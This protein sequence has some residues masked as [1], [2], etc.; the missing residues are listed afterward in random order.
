MAEI[1]ENNQVIV[2]REVPCTVRDGVKLYANIYR[3]NDGGIYPILL[4]RLPY[5]KNLPDF[6]HR[7]I[8]P[9]RTAMNGFIVV[10]QD[11]RG[12]FAS[13]GEFM[14]FE[15]EAED[16]Y[17]TVEW[18]ARLPYSDGN[19]GMFGLSYYGFTQLYAALEKPPSLKAVFP[20]MTGSISGEAF[21]RDGVFN[22]ASAETWILESVAPDYLKRKQ[23]SS[24]YAE[25]IKV[26]TNDLNKIEKWH[27]FKPINQWPPVTKHPELRELFRKYLNKVYLTD[28]LSKGT[29]TS[30]ELKLPAYHLAGWYDNFLGPTIKNYQ[31][32]KK[33]DH[34]QK[35]II[36]PWGHGAFNSE[37]GERSFGIT[38]SGLSIEGKEDITSLH[39]N[40]FDYWLKQDNT[41]LPED[42]EPI[43]IFVM[44]I[45]QWRSEKEWPLKRTNNTPYYFHSNGN[46][47]ANLDSGTLTTV[48]P[49]AEQ[50]D[51]F[52][53]D[54]ESP[55]PTN[56]GSVLFYNGKNAGPRD[57]SEIEQRKDVLVYSSKPINTPIEVTGWVKV[58][59]WAFTDAPDTDF[60][61]KL[62]D[63]FPDGT[64]YNLTDGI[65]RTSHV[66]GGNGQ[67]NLSGKTVKY[68]IDLWATSNVFL[69]GHKIRVE[70]SS[71]NYPWYDV[72]PNTGETTLDTSEMVQ[73]TQT[74][75]HDS[76][77]PSHLVLPVIPIE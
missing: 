9:I 40:W 10:I 59:L 29:F 34:N 62:V 73:A 31:D 18:A 14:P 26:I 35:L 11:V 22:F 32:M 42:D 72:N 1:K 49:E 51:Q 55:V 21:S 48:R 33:S 30:E 58:V 77:H 2:D 61:A 64:A 68:E 63:V 69:S 71:S 66:S 47:N 12:R 23:D 44:G 15:Q 8:D 24:E 53:Y 74:I 60:T 39:I 37:I 17:D 52:V 56:G 41:V 19:V 5:N 43:K 6:S 57:Q 45:N 7:Y 65:V 28:S 76:E 3:P 20:A 38:S 50:A 70:I 27:D 25:T 67:E 46:A 13:E 4:C 54:P 36:G 75:V 16:G